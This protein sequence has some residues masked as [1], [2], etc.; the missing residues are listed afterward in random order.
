MRK[1][2]ISVVL[3]LLVMTATAQNVTNVRFEQEGKMVKIYYDLSEE[4][5]VSIYL[6]TDGGNTYES[7]PLGHL[8]GHAG[9]GVAA[10]ASRCAVWDV[11][12]D[13]EKLQGSDVRF[14]IV[15][16]SRRGNESFTI[17]GVRFTMV[18]VQG[19]TFTMGCTSEQGDDCWGDEKP[20]HSVTLS[21]Y[22]IGETEVTQAL[23]REVMGTTPSYFKGDNLPVENVSW[24]DAQEFCRKLSQQTGITFRLPTE[25]EWEYA[26]RGGKKSRGYKYSGSNTLSSVAWYT[27]NSSDH[28]HPVKGK[29]ANELGLYDMSGNV[30]EWC[31]DWFGEYGSYSQTNPTGASLGSYRVLR[32]GDYGFTANYCRVASRFSF[33]PTFLRRGLRVVLVR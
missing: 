20:A 15:A 11:L 23:W 5:D 7:S 17:G 6:S 22:Y 25:A 27:D 26:T 3:C 1:L 13:R 9:D 12:A 19:G 30:W 18:Y 10:G 24:N 31:Q 2:M 32:G 8:S 33:D 29:Q 14:K 21:G 4:A 16:E 28:T